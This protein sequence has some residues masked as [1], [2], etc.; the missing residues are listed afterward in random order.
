MSGLVWSK[1]GHP[2]DFWG[3]DSGDVKRSINLYG[4]TPGGNNLWKIKDGE[5]WPIDQDKFGFPEGD[6]GEIQED[7]QV[8]YYADS[9]ANIYKE[10]GA[11]DTRKQSDPIFYAYF[12]RDTNEG[13][14][15][16]ILY[17]NNGK[18]IIK[19]VNEGDEEP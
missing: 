2:L 6:L 14:Y 4:K 9:L 18:T 15:A 13:S 7:I 12:C 1:T 17:M 3:A 16:G 5:L 8:D 11:D 19:Q 10:S